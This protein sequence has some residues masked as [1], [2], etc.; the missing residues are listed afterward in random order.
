MD[1]RNNTCQNVFIHKT[2]E[3]LIAAFTDLWVKVINENEQRKQPAI[4]ENMILQTE[5]I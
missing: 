1:C 2:T 4:F 5:D 3:E